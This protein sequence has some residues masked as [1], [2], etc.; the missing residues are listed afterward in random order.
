[1]THNNLNPAKLVNQPDQL[2]A[3]VDKLHNERQIALDTESNSLFA[4]YECVCLLQVSALNG[5]SQIEDYIIDPFAISDLSDFGSVL[6]SPDVEVI[7]HG[8]EYDIMSLKRDFDFTFNNIFDTHLAARTL[9]IERVGLS[10]LLEEYFG[11]AVDK[12]HQQSNWGKRPLSKSQLHYAQLD[13]H[14]LIPLRDL[15][16]EKLQSSAFLPEFEETLAHM[17]NLPPIEKEFDEEGFWKIKAARSLNDEELA[18]LRDIY[19][20]RENIAS[21]INRPPFKVLQNNT[22]V[23]LAREQPDN[24]AALGEVRG[25][26][27]H[28]VRRY[29]QA[30]ISLIRKARTSPPP[31]PRSQPSIEQDTLNRYE[32]LH[33]WRKNLA[34]KQGVESDIIMSKQALWSLA[35]QVPRTMEA[36]KDIEDLGEYR[37]QKYGE[38]LLKVLQTSR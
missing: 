29:G 36:L 3:L 17:T 1:M 28:F 35:T 4:Y 34:A 19:L 24:L 8:A 20:W 16:N 11:I 9:G 14:Y 31:A 26:P 33:S 27:K 38:A 25:F 6:A 30:L 13:S 37:R 21:E 12:R 32:A 18:I 5:K 10:S 15:L 23:R 7:M 22:M 2:K